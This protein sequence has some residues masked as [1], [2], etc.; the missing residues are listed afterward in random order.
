MKAR[1]AGCLA[2]QIDVAARGPTFFSL[3]FRDSLD[4]L[5]TC[6]PNLTWPAGQAGLERESREERGKEV[7]ARA[8]EGNRGLEW[9]QFVTR[10]PV[11]A[12]GSYFLFAVCAYLPTYHLY[13]LLRIT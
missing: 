13:V 6:T 2:L 8:R 9:G 11:E 4:L 12:A 7:G 1:L 10:P 5:A 3:S